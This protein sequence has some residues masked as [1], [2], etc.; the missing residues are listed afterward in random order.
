MTEDIQQLLQIWLQLL[1]NISKL[2]AAITLQSYMRI[3]YCDALPVT[4]T[5]HVSI[6]CCAIGLPIAYSLYN[7]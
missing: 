1:Q 4:D 7:V 2:P 5:L 6:L 3:Y